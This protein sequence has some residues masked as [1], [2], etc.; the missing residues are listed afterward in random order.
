MAAIIRPYHICNFAE[1]LFVRIII[2]KLLLLNIPTLRIHPYRRYRILDNRTKQRIS[3]IHTSLI[4]QI[5]ELRYQ[6]KGLSISLKMIQI[7]PHLRLEHLIYGFSMENQTAQILS[8]PLSNSLFSKM[9]K[10][11]IPDI[12]NQ[13][14]T[15]KDITDIFLHL[16]RK[17]SILLIC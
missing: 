3:Q 14:R 11:R 5:M 9:A 13:P 17:S 1:Y 2:S 12:M 10:R 4:Y 15:L 16:H 6:S 8:K 7:F